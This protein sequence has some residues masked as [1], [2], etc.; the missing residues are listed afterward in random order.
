MVST[1]LPG[2][3]MV[4]TSYQIGKITSKETIIGFAKKID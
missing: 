1:I 3:K 2:N 4:L